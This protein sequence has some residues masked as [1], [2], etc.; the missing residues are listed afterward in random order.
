MDASVEIQLFGPLT[1]RRAGVAAAL[2]PSRKLRALLAWLAL[3]PRPVA[4]EA[5]CE[6]LWDRT[7]DPRAELRGAL[8][9]LRPLLDSPSCER[10]R[11]EGDGV[12]LDTATLAV[13][14][15]EVEAAAR[16]G[17]AALDAPALR[18]L[19]ARFRGE[20]LAGGDLPDQAAFTAWLLGQRRRWRALHAAVL[21]HL[22]AALPPAGDEA[23]AVM[24]QWLQ[25]APLDRH[26]H[27]RLLEALAR[28]GDLR[29]GDEH[30]AAAVRLFESEGQDAAAL[31]QAWRAARQRP[32]AS[33]L[34]VPA[35]AEPAVPAPTRRASIAVMPFDDPAGDLGRA[36][37]YDVTARLARLR[38]MFVIAQGSAHA[39]GERGL[40]AGEAARALGVDYV[41]S[42]QLLRR[43]GR[44]GL[45][46]QLVHTRSERVLWADHL[47]VA[48]RDT[49]EML[50]ALGRQLV[51][52]LA[53]QVEL[54]E[55]QLA[56]LKPPGQLDA[57]EA[58]HRGLWHMYRFDRADNEQARRCFEQAIALDPTFSRPWAGL[59]FTHFQNAFLGWGDHAQEAEF[60]YRSAAQGVLA[61]EQDPAARWALGRAQWL[62]G[63]LAESLAELEAAVDLSPNFSQ[64]HYTLAF[65]NAQSGDAHAAIDSADR[66]RRLSP[67]D[68][69]L[70]AMLGARALALM[71]LGRHDEAAQWALKAAARPNAHHQIQAIAACCLAL[72][73]RHEEARRML[74]TLRA[75]HPGYGAREFLA[76]FRMDEAGAAL[77]QRAVPLLS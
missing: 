71:R 77:V 17:L 12:S 51:A 41:A 14:A 67:Y 2:P 27:E 70:F 65:V 54:S 36:L 47:E 60:A 28:R 19:A 63:S 74:A 22:A 55:R 4:R 34:V 21:E 25:V 42:G 59:S 8:S 62:R 1:L 23:L 46:V 3:A 11:S 39:L 37:A 24:T 15:L 29:A 5:L 72:A 31:S 50:E 76:A 26:A 56:R 13:D 7:A 53:N 38:S 9:R 75:G 73:E 40:G 52:A 66:A 20:F 45:T 32:A 6:L 10:L 69:M 44:V 16:A 18:T 58:H 64:G 33:P 48:R 30:L 57:W 61:D 68:P 49:F 43:A 35:G